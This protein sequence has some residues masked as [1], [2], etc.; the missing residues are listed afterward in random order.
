MSHEITYQLNLLDSKTKRIA[1]IYLL[2]WL[3]K[4]GDE[5]AKHP[6]MDRIRE[7]KLD[8]FF[9]KKNIEFD[10][11]KDIPI[12]TNII[13]IWTEQILYRKSLD[14]EARRT[15]LKRFRDEDFFKTLK[16]DKNRKIK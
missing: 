10:K 2:N 11:V 6:Y 16:N 7:L 4:N 13:R 5:I 1:E 8:I 9:N 12:V 15:K 14:I 3:S